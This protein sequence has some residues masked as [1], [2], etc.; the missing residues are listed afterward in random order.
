MAAMIEVRG[1]RREFGSFELDVDQLVVEQGQFFCLLGPSGSGKTVLLES[2]AGHHRPR[3][4]DVYLDG[5]R[6]TDE[7]ANRRSVG[8]LYQDGAL[9][10]H[11]S[12]RENI[13]FGLRYQRMSRADRE[14]RVQEVADW[15]GLDHLL[16]RPGVRGLSGGEARRVALARTLAPAPSVVLLDEPTSGLDRPQREDLFVLFRRLTADLG[17]T[18][19]QV[20]HELSEAAAVAHLVGLIF[21]GQIR[22]T[23]E[24][25]DVLREPTDLAAARFLG[26]DNCF[27]VDGLDSSGRPEAMG[28]PWTVAKPLPE[29][30]AW[31]MFRPEDVNIATGAV[32]E[33]NAIEAAITELVDRAD[34]VH[35]AAALGDQRIEAHV[36]S[37][38][39]TRLGL[40]L[41]QTVTFVVP[42]DACHLIGD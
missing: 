23:G 38:T 10:P 41:G 28:T 32:A 3:E 27:A 2:I 24:L 11:L 29:Q 31:L 34:Y 18:V 40:R 35:V 13:A 7:P 17:M 1:L 22:Q 20:T 25:S 33:D 21:E 39:C 4:G 30:P 19:I 42:P 6:A 36:S 16:D 9:F 5:R 37:A 26:V 12:V 8:L 14:H 15:V